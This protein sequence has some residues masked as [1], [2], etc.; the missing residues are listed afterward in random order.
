MS[1]RPE[2][3]VVSSPVNETAAG[4]A[5][6]RLTTIEPVLLSTSVPPPKVLVPTGRKLP[7]LLKTSLAPVRSTRPTTSPVA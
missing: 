2:L 7:A 1:I 5:P 4:A 6:P 3:L